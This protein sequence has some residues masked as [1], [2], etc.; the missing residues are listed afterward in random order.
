VSFSG[1][2][3]HAAGEPWLGRNAL[4]A[5]VMLLVS[6][7]LW[8]QRLRPGA[9]VHGI[10]V[11]GGDAPNVIPSRTSAR[12]MLRSPD[13][14]ELESMHHAFVEM[15]EAAAS[16]T[17]CVS[18]IRFSGRS[19]TML[20]NAV[21]RRCFARNLEANG[22]TDRPSSGEAS[23]GSS[24]MGNVSHV[25]PTIHPEIAM[26]DEGTPS[27]SIAFRDAAVTERADDVVVLAAIVTAQTAY[28]VLGDPDL[29]ADAWAAF[30]RDSECPGPSRGSR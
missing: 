27:H 14:T 1:Q 9:R 7:G 16:A 6:I 29:V 22:E 20:D 8:R 2:A 13:E 26:C 24:D 19:R 18:T 12:F 10:I 5:L 28:D 21:L 11:D 17:G 3:A 4:D 25:V 23:A 15:A 30:R